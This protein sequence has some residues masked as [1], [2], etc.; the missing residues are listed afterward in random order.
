MQ[1]P[2]FTIR[3]ILWSIVVCAVVFAWAREQGNVWNAYASLRDRRLFLLACLLAPW[4]LARWFGP[5]IR[6]RRPRSFARI[7]LGVTIPVLFSLGWA[8]QRA[9]REIE[10]L[11]REF[12]YPDD[13]ILALA[14]WYDVRHPTPPGF[15]NLHGGFPCVEAMLFGLILT[16]A[17]FTGALFGL[18]L[19]RRGDHHEP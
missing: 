16:L 3:A 9:T 4:A 10:D 19:S 14:R 13:A 5:P 8:Y 17:P 18:M 7:V 6:G 1:R 11:G 2:R 15:I 12:P